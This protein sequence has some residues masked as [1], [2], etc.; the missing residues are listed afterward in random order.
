MRLRDF[1]SPTAVKLD[2]QGATKDDILK[3]LIVLIGLD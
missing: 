1:F 2:L 3:E